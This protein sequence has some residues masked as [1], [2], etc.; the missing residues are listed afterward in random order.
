MDV[1][2]LTNKR[3]ES[4]KRFD[5]IMTKRKETEKIIADCDT[6]LERLRGEYRAYTD[7][8]DGLNDPATTIVAEADKKGERRGRK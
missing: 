4:E 5:E 7:L 6:E 1:D 3:R 8:I 2:T